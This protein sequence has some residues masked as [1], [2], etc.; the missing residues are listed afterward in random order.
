MLINYQVDSFWKFNNFINMKKFSKT[1]KISKLNILVREPKIK[2]RQ[3][4]KVLKIEI[5]GLQHLAENIFLKWKTLSQHVKEKKIERYGRDW[6]RW[7]NIKKPK[8]IK[9]LKIINC[10]KYVCGTWVHKKIPLYKFHKET[11]SSSWINL[12]CGV[13]R[14]ALWLD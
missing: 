12:L 14:H 3:W 8:K 10:K 13:R 4:Q 11:E 7:K 5:P 2:V 6:K 1:K 9:K